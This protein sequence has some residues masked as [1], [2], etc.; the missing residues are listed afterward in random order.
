MELL[1]VLNSHAFAQWLAESLAIFFL[2][3]GFVV[4]AIG[5]GLFFSSERTLRLF[6]TLNRWVSMRR[7]TRPLEIVRDTRPAV[8]RY[9]RWIAA[10]CILG[11]VFALYG[12]FTHFDAKAVIYV[13]RL[14]LFKP[15]FA[16]WVADSARWILILGNAAAIVVGIALAFSPGAVAKLEDAGSR[17]YSERQA[18]K[19]A[20]DMKTHL[21]SRVATYPRYSGVIMMF[22]GLVLIGVFGSM[23]A[24]IR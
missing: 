23:L 24:G 7:T 9:R 20:D 6:G 18:T 17:W 15:S 14:D 16:A 21:D 2:L 1:R 22:F 13:Y 5:L 19:G 3:G 4:L 11:G 10:G 8:L 12:L